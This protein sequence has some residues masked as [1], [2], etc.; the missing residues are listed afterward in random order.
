MIEDC[1][2]VQCIIVGLSEENKVTKK[3][4]LYSYKMVRRN[5][6]KLSQYLWSTGPKT[7]IHNLNRS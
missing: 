7:G 6:T 1:G 3:K 2:Y 4:R 5:A